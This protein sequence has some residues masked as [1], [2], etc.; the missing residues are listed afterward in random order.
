MVAKLQDEAAC[1]S[2]VDTVDEG[3][4]PLLFVLPL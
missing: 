2:M 3:V 1:A 4:P